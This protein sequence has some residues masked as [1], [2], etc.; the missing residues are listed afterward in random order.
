MNSNERAAILAGAT[1]TALAVLLAVAG[2]TKSP[3][4]EAASGHVVSSEV[5]PDGGLVVLT[6][7]AGAQRVEFTS[8][9]WPQTLALMGIQS[10]TPRYSIGQV[11]GLPLD[12][13]QDPGNYGVPGA[14]VVLGEPDGVACNAGAPL[15]ELWLQ[16][17]PDAPWACACS[18][19]S[20]CQWRPPLYPSGLGDLT[21]AP[22][23]VTLAS[24]SWSGAG[25]I[26]KPCQELAGVS[27]WPGACPIGP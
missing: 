1:A 8:L 17:N 18:S 19:G 9:L 26:R 27:S 21:S 11:C 3:G 4:P 25:C 13:G 22:L 10:S 12:G 14:I 5:A 20:G 2:G 24:G 15:L 16:G 7:P 23:G 6:A